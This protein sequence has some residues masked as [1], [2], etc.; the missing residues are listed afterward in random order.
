MIRG[1]YALRLCVMNDTCERA[2]VER[3]VG[4]FGEALGRQPSGRRRP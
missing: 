3:V 1:T 2:D 4:F